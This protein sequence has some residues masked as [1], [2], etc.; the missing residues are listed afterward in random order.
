MLKNRLIQIMIILL[1]GIGLIWGINTVLILNVT[2]KSI[3]PDPPLTQTSLSLTQ[4]EESVEPHSACSISGTEAVLLIYEQAG[5]APIFQYVYFDFDLPALS[6][7]YIPGNLGVTSQII[8]S[9]VQPTPTLASAYQYLT[10]TYQ[11]QKNQTVIISTLMAQIIFENLSITAD[12]YLILQQEAFQW[13]TEMLGG[14][15]LNLPYAIQV[16]NSTLMLD[17][18]A[19]ILTSEPVFYLATFQASENPAENQI[20]MERMMLLTKGILAQL[21]KNGG[22]QLSSK[23]FT[24]LG[25]A[26]QTDMKITT[27]NQL[28]CFINTLPNQAVHLS[29][30]S[31]DWFRENMISQP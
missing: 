28:I 27:I 19:N 4:T 16:P 21:E 1:A 10:E 26:F 18:G 8:P 25:T 14:I 20:S 7:L 2:G 31:T 15:Q 9:E 30:P 29:A 13:I 22:E 11:Q 5:I 17:A 3:Q 23:L 24:N 12:H 6:V